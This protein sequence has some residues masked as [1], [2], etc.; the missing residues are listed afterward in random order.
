MPVEIDAAKLA[1]SSTE[2]IPVPATVFRRN[3][4]CF[5]QWIWRQSSGPGSSKPDGER[6]IYRVRHSG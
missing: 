2:K 5:W 3:P 1:S 6:R 4:F